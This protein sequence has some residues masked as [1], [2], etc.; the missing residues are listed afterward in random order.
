[1]RPATD[2]DMERER[3]QNRARYR[4]KSVYIEWMEQRAER[5]KAYRAERVWSRALHKYVPR[6]RDDYVRRP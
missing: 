4:R 3:A 5:A 6:P 2:E 1:M